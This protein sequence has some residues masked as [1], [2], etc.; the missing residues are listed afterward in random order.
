[1]ALASIAVAPALVQAAADARTEL[2]R[3]SLT[4][5]ASGSDLRSKS[6]A[7]ANAERAV[8]VQ[9][10]TEFAR[11]GGPSL[12]LTPDQLAAVVA[13]NGLPRGGNTSPGGTFAYNDYTGF[14]RIGT[15]RP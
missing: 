12:S 7:V 10:A 2:V 4:V 13:N 1:M 3:A 9:L 14:T 15:A 5:P 6:D 8:A 11:V